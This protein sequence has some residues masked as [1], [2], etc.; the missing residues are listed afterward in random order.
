[1]DPLCNDGCWCFCA[2][3]HQGNHG[4][5]TYSGNCRPVCVPCV[6]HP[7]PGH[8]LLLQVSRVAYLP[9]HLLLLQ[10]S[11]CPISRV[12][13][14]YFRSVVCPI[15]QVIVCCFRSIVGPIPQVIVCY[16]RSV[17]CPISQVI[18]LLLQVSRVSHLPDHRLLLQVRRV[19]IFVHLFNC[20][21]KSVCLSF[22]AD[23]LLL[24]SLFIY[25]IVTSSE[26]VSSPSDR[27]LL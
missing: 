7:L 12:I 1:M 9:G 2:S 23:L 22:S 19:F 21:F 16:F 25:L 27:L 4:D 14:Y 17:L 13:F 24:L 6:H 26:C 11:L 18:F 10:V 15:P 20:F 5:G 8:L 3:A